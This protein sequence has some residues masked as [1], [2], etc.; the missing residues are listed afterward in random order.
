[1]CGLKFTVDRN[2][3]IRSVD[4]PRDDMGRLFASVLV[5]QIYHRFF[6]FIPEGGKDVVEQVVQEGV[7]L[8]ISGGQATC[9]CGEVRANIRITPLPGDDGSISGAEVGLE[10]V[11][12]C[13]M[14]DALQ[15]WRRLIDIGRSSAALAHGVRNPLNTI[16][17]AVV[18]LKDTYGREPALVEFVEIIEDEISRLDGFVTRFLRST[19]LESESVPLDVNELLRRILAKNNFQACAK[20]VT[21][22]AEF[23]GLPEVNA[24]S[25]QLEHAVMNVINNSLEAMAEGGMLRLKTETAWRSDREY[26]CI[27]VSDTGRGMGRNALRDVPDWEGKSRRG[28]GRGFGLFITREIV[29]SHGGHLEIFSRKDIGTTVRI[30]IPA[31]SV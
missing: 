9:F 28:D 18:Y 19:L 27:E 7:P 4:I 12:G 17:G 11:A 30:F 13:R 22:D 2:L 14:P 25:F 10:I 3:I 21:L 23:G 1:M 16:K 8:F 24:D 15:R 20:K 26:V 6:S 31:D 5:G 29:Q